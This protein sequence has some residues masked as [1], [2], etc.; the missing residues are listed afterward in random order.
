[1]D[2]SVEPTDGHELDR[3]ITALLNA[4]GAMRR[5]IESVDHSPEVD[6]E[7]VIGLVAERLAGVLALLAEHRSDEELALGTQLV[8]ET[9]LLVADDLGLGYCFAGD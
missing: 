2:I 1:M 3:F 6:G 7:A 5:I 4:T 9:T 8:A